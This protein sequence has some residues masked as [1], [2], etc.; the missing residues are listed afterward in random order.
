MPKSSAEKH[1]RQFPLF[2]ASVLK[3]YTRERWDALYPYL[4]D[5]PRMSKRFLEHFITDYARAHNCCYPLTDPETGQT[6][7]FNVFH[8]AQTVLM[9]V[10]KCF[11]DPFD[12]R[13]KDVADDGFIV[14]GYGAKKLRVNVCSLNF[15]RWAYKNQVLA[16]AEKHEAAIKA[17]M[18]EMSKLKRERPIK[19]IHIDVP[20]TIATTGEHPLRDVYW[21]ASTSDKMQHRKPKRKRYRESSVDIV[22]NDGAKVTTTFPKRV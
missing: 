17:D 18:A 19:E 15:F 2:K 16:Y 1:W 21:Q 3:W 10:H 5:P 14:H 6:Q 9:G 4:K 8:S 22:V 11:M 12:R 20:R 7:M 13:N